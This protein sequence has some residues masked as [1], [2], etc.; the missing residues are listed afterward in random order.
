L[1]PEATAFGADPA[2]GL[3]ESPLPTS[4]FSTLAETSLVVGID[5]ILRMITVQ[6]NHMRR[7]VCNMFFNSKYQKH[8]TITLA[9][10]RFVESGP[11][12]QVSCFFVDSA[13]ANLIGLLYQLQKRG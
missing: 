1:P 5:I 12:L 4:G 7:Q 8:S 11:L 2:L 13:F 9:H 3:P 10:S 6:L